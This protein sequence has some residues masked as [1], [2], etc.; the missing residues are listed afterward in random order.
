MYR[1][2]RNTNPHRSSLIELLPLTVHSDGL[3]PSGRESHPSVEVSR[4]PGRPCLPVFFTISVRKRNRER[5]DREGRPPSAKKRKRETC[6]L[7]SKKPKTWHPER[8]RRRTPENPDWSP[9]M[10]TERTQIP[11]T[12]TWLGTMTELGTMVDETKKSIVYRTSPW[13]RDTGTLI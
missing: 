7:R 8:G 12:W 11:T 2:L 6:S 4:P 13:N 9:N 3:S 1:P 5:G 10:V